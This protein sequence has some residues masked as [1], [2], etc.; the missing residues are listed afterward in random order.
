MTLQATLLTRKH[1][2]PQHTH[3]RALVYLD[4]QRQQHRGDD[5]GKLHAAHRSA[6]GV[7]GDAQREDTGDHGH[8]QQDERVDHCSGAGERDG[9]KGRW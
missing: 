9:R 1:T 2:H 4:L 8:H 3:T 7:D 5:A 6:R